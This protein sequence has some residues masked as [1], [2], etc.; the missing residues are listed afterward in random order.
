MNRFVVERTG[1]Q[2]SM[3]PVLLA[4][5]VL[6]VTV[7]VSM[8][9]SASYFRASNLFGDPLYF[10]RRQVLWVLLGT[11]GAVVASRISLGLLQRHMRLILG[12][13]LLLM[14]LTFVPGIGTEFLGARR[15]IFVFGYSVQPSELAKLTVVLYL[16]YILSRKQDR[17]D[18]AVNALLPPLIVVGVVALLIYLQN[19]FST[20]F[21]IVF[22]ALAVFFVADM[23]LRYFTGLAVMTFPLGLILLLSREH[24]VNRIISFIEP[25]WDPAGTGYQVATSMAALRAGGLWGEGIGRSAE[26]IGRLP[27]AHSDFVFAVVAE[28]IGFVGMLLIFALFCVFAYRGYLI[29]YLATDRFVSL[30]AFGITSVVMLQALL[31]FAVVSGLVPATGVPL[32]FFSSGGSSVFMT[33]VNSGLLLNLSRYVEL[34]E[35]VEWGGAYHG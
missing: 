26:K 34:P 6:L 24:R 9:F 2:R 12:V 22:V 30:S 15:W 10:F 31:N 16:A 4:V 27:E 13:T 35:S 14:L 25:E 8:L 28:E 19:D 7:G 11:A 17:M 29:A 5:L 1:N 23:P 21:F 32:P 3:D 20:A 18:D 33:L